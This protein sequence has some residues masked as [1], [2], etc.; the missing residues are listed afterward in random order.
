MAVDQGVVEFLRI[1]NVRAAEVTA[2]A[3]RRSE[4]RGKQKV[5]IN[6]AHSRETT[7]S[8]G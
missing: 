3:K 7:G 4:L 5:Y 1:S 6:A 2:I 8:T